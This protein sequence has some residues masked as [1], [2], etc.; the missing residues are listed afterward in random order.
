MAR[1]AEHPTGTLPGT[2]VGADKHLG[3]A[4]PNQIPT[5]PTQYVLN[6][7]LLRNL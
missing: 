5:F 2:T 4:H 6:A 3:L 7:N 1:K